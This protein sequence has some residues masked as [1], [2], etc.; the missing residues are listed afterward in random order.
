V[1]LLSI[2]FLVILGV[3]ILYL[4]SLSVAFFRAS[5]QRVT[6]SSPLSVIVCAHDEEDNLRELIPLLLAQQYAEYEVIIIDD[7][8]NDNTYDYLLEATRQ[9]PQLKMVTV[10]ETPAHVNGKK[11]GITLAVKAARYDWLVFTDADC[12]PRSSTWLLEM[13]RC[14][15]Q[16]KSIALGVS[17][18]RRKPG[19]LN[20]FIRFESLLTATQYIGWALLG[21]PY[22]GVGRNLAYR[23]NLFIENKGFNRHLSVTGGDD[24]LF[25]NQH[26]T[27][28]NTAC[29]IG[30]EALV[31]SEPKQTWADFYY[32]KIRHLSVGKRYRWKHKFLLGMFSLTWIFTW[33]L[34]LPLMFFF[35]GWQWVLAVFVVRQIILILL[36]HRASRRFGD[37]F[38]S[39]KTPVL[40][41]IYAFYYL[42]AGPVA[43]LAKKVRW[44]N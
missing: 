13:S 39:W 35:S 24:D 44:K 18:Y 6:T 41:F 42:V 25:V 5:R 11:F 17:L 1:S 8:S 27:S 26:A 2:T 36:I 10:K 33:L 3:H 23:K 9:Y 19:F 7:R 15:H 40:D 21:N 32:Q 29:A 30:A 12:R 34:V 38:E 31:F 22:M 4:A 37:P 14:F 20:S 16:D 28:Q 43:L